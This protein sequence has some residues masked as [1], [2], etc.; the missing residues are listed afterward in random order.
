MTDALLDTVTTEEGLRLH[1]EHMMQAHQ[2]LSDYSYDE[3]VRVLTVAQYVS[4]LC[5]KE[6]KD[7][8]YA[9][10]PGGAAGR[11]RAHSP[12]AMEI[13]MTDMTIGERL[14]LTRQV[15]ERWG[16][17]SGLSEALLEAIKIVL[18]GRR[19]MNDPKD[20]FERIQE[21]YAEY[22]RDQSTDQK[23]M[24]VWEQLHPA[25]AGALM[26]MYHRGVT[27]G[28]Q[29]VHEHYHAAMR[30]FGDRVDDLGLQLHLARAPG[31]GT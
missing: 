18:K 14:R 30:D 6:I 27:D 29:Q 3:V 20:S 17:F 4:D 10:R 12:N 15:I 1:A 5:I 19:A 11:K 9:M 28:R 16:N 25:I 7:Q 24:L 13:S 22:C 23:R 31:R 2:D 8:R 21:L 26:R